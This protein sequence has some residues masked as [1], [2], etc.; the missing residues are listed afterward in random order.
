V[1]LFGIAPMLALDFTQAA[2]SNLTSAYQ[3]AIAP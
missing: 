1:I 2:V 3:A